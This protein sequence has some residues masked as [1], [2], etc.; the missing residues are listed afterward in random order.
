MIPLGYDPA[1]FFVGTQSVEDEELVLALLGRLVPEK[2]VRDAVHV[3]EQVN[4]VRPARLKIVGSGPEEGP[5]R[6]LAT[7]LGVGDRLQVEPWR[8]ATEVAEIYRR[9]HVVLVPSVATSTWAEQFGRVIVEGQASGAVVVGYASGSIPG[10][11]GDAAVLVDPGDVSR[12]ADE[13]ARLV[14]DPDAYT[15]YREQGLALS[16]SRTWARVSERQ[17]D[18]YRR[19]LAGETERVELPRS[20]RRKRDLARSEFGPTAPTGA[21]SRPF[22][23]PLL[24]GGGVVPA[25]QA[26]LLDARAEVI[27]RI[28]PPARS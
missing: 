15:A 2:G 8:P 24:R 6:E 20:P 16:R 28:R 10:V 3:L 4:S 14:S 1:L 21:G 5:A 27:A 13:V 17:G 11:A 9:T 7:A 26:A 18:L 12:L 23:L 25:V 22:A 19:V